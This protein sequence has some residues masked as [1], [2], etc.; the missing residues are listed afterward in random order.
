MEA[1]HPGP[2][3]EP[4]SRDPL[5]GLYTRSTF[6]QALAARLRT[7][8][9]LAGTAVV[10]LAVDRLDSINETFG[11]D[12]R[13]R[14]VELLGRVVQDSLASR[15][16]AARYGEGT[17]ALLLP[18]TTPTEV[19]A[20]VARVQAGVQKSNERGGL[21]VTLQLR[22]G[23]AFG[24]SQ[25]DRDLLS[26]AERALG[27]GLSPAGH[28][29]PA[30]SV[31]RPPSSLLSLPAQDE[32][33]ILIVD[34][35]PHVTRLVQEIL[36]GTGA[37][38]LAAPDA[39]EAFRQLRSRMVDIVIAD[40]N[41]PGINGLEMLKEIRAADP[42]VT[43]I[44][45]TG[46]RDLELA[47]HAIRSGA[48]DY[49]VKPFTP[50]DLRD[51]VALGLMKRQLILGGKAYQS[52]LERQV[53]DRTHELQ[54][55]IRHL[56]S[57]YRDTL[58]ALGA[59]L[60][61]RDVE[62]HAHSERVAQYALTLGR[63][64]SMSQTDLTTLER[65]VYLHDI[66]KIG[67]PDRV[68]LKQGAL[69]EEEWVV[70]KQ[71]SLLGYRLASRVDFLKGASKIILAHHERFDGS[72]YP[73]GL[74]G[75][76][77][78]IGARVFAVVDALDAI[79]SDRPYRKAKPFRDAREEIRRFSGRQF[80]PAVIEA[81]LSVPEPIWSGIRESVNRQADRSAE[82]CAAPEI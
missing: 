27:T 22:V 82:E 55:V 50:E 37:V 24:R 25:A 76:A 80:D 60:D 17:I 49:L 32:A 61:T 79:T 21:P 34:D 48:D 68:L 39:G 70:M 54:Q 78:P 45:I 6:E 58:K 15:D 8:C 73:H 77:I 47:V 40:I 2:D 63:T 10:L 41:L 52:I 71:H 19:E 66:G 43:V 42:T 67:I 35:H 29:P 13:D 69:T 62:T 46:S 75:E 28:E 33:V 57:T 53:E 65:G 7:V 23:T 44:M 59:A 14:A 20:V 12:V 16:L 11:Q 74:K 4:A 31:N 18:E 38:T 36:A 5:T 51:S 1:L 64:L 26:S 3:Q 9:D 56:E 30:S 81:F 72:G